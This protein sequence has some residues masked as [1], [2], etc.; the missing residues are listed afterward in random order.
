MDILK[1]LWK[2][3]DIF[4][5]EESHIYTNSLNTNFKS[6]TAF[7]DEFCP[8]PDWDAILKR[9]SEKTGEATEVIK[10]RWDAAG[11]YARTLGTE[12][13]SVMENIWKHKNYPGNIAKMKEYD[14]MIKDFYERKETCIKLYNKM[15]NI[16]EPI[17]NEFIVYDVDNCITGTV[18]FLAYNKKTEKIDLIDW[19]TSKEFKQ[20]NRREKMLKPFDKFDDCNINHYSLQLSLY[21][22]MIE[23]KTN[24]KIDK[25]IL[26]QIPAIAYSPM[27][28]EC[29]NFGTIL[30][31]VL[32]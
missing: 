12:I 32:K 28:C 16:W 30:K 23:K 1:E 5:E 24:L 27:S 11:E 19:K 26:F 18:D 31:E 15:K 22:Y 29:K 4:F 8:K 25:M 10:A 13:H 17:V 7:V 9:K 21:K 6:C 20:E 3:N 2:F 14:G